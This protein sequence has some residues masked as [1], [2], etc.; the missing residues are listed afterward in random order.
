MRYTYC[1]TLYSLDEVNVYLESTLGKFSTS[2]G[3]F[4]R[5]ENMIILLNKG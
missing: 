4:V 1:N 3:N 2:R 5:R